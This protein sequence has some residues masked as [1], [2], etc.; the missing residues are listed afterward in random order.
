[1][2]SP[3]P[4]V[5]PWPRRARGAVAGLVAT[6]LALG[7]AELVAA[8]GRSLRS[9][10]VDVGSRVIDGA[11]RWLKD[12]AISTFGTNDKVALIVGIV[13]A[14]VAYAILIGILATRRRWIGPV[15]V[16]L[17]V[18]VGVLSA[19]AGDGGLLSV[20]PT[21]VGGAVGA[22]ALWALSGWPAES[23]TPAAGVSAGSAGRRTFLLASAGLAAAAVVAGSAGRWLSKRFDVAV[24]RANLR[25]PTP[26]QPLA[27]P[28]AGVAFADVKGLTP[29][30]TPNANFYRIDTA[31]V[32]PQVPID[33][34]RLTIDGLVDRPMELT[35]DD[36]TSRDVVEADVTLTCVSN[37]VG[38]ELAGNA[39][40]LG[41]RLDD[42]LRDAGRAT[43]APTRWSATPSTA[44]PPGSPSRW[45]WTAAT[46]SSPSG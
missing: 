41:V 3:T 10:V 34:W 21:L 42:L 16:G 44:S 20:L 9:P 26:A 8:V 36:L 17:F 11:P 5:S 2:D 29:F 40:W 25:L 6:A 30:V 4:H 27:P 31:L 12:F 43:T 13:V 45:R 28:P 33:T 37:E 24:D 18:V 35:F 38:G 22:A 32:V 7:V 15:G 14:L 1:M 23:P 19:T 46:R 39:R